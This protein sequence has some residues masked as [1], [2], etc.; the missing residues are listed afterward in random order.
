MGRL[1]EIL[2]DPTLSASARRSAWAREMDAMDRLFARA[3]QSDAAL[4]AAL[5]RARSASLPETSG[6]LLT[7]DA[8]RQVRVAGRPAGTLDDLVDQVRQAN[9][10]SAAHGLPSE[11]VVVVHS[12]VDGG[13]SPI[14]VLPRQR[15]LPAPAVE[16]PPPLRDVP[17]SAEGRYVVDIGVAGSGYGVEMVPQG[18]RSRG[19]LVQTDV[20]EYATA[21]QQRRDLS[22]EGPGPVRDEGSVL[23]LGDALSNLE[24]FFG[25]PA[26]NRGVRL[27]TINSV[28]AAYTPGQY[29]RLAEGLS[30]SMGRGGRV[31]VRWDT[32]PERLPS[33][34]MAPRGHIDGA[35][36][37]QELQAL[38]QRRVRIEDLGRSPVSRPGSIESSRVGG[39]TRVPPTEQPT[40]PD[41]GSRTG[42]HVVITFEN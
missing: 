4:Q 33:G 30:E 25:R 18:T 27:M 19:P 29:R 8:R 6:Q 35:L 39:G 28:N 12:S 32:A 9:N 2:N 17:A 14:Q 13:V 40:P 23:V 42:R 5:A 26:Q 31:E 1:V 22:I 3:V 15:P 38:G 21:A 20:A 37:G 41:P 10:V 16:L 36:L 34:A 24:L 7:V 11:Y